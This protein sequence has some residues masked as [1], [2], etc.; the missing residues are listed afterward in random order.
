MKKIFV[1]PLC[2]LC[3]CNISACRSNSDT[4]NTSDVFIEDEVSFTNEEVN[5]GRRCGVNGVSCND[6]A[7]TNY[8]RTEADYRAY[9]ERTKRDH[10]Y[11]QAATGNNLTATVRPGVEEDV[12]IA[13]AGYRR[14][15][16]RQQPAV[17]DRVFIETQ[18][19][20]VA[21]APRESYSAP[22]MRDEQLGI[23]KK[24]AP[25]L[26]TTLLDAPAINPTSPKGAGAEYITVK[27]AANGR[28]TT[29]IQSTVTEEQSITTDGQST[30]TNQHRYEVTCTEECDDFINQ[31][32]DIITSEFTE[33]SFDIAD[34]IDDTED[35]TEVKFTD[36][37]QET[38]VV[39]DIS[40]DEI[41]ISDDTVLTWEAEEGD[42]LRE[43]LTKWS[44]MAGWK[45][46]WQTNRNYILS[47]GVMFKG[48]F[49]DVSSALIRAFARARPAP[50]A[51]YYK[52][53]R[54]I[55]VETMEN[56]NAY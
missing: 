25:A 49:A 31:D 17:E 34:Y 38:K 41:K 55:V 19:Q 47:A 54:V 56:E 44:A 43:L 40:I 37:G 3:V 23:T 53:N 14:T 29:R 22:K 4:I 52:G 26:E 11:T 18:T 9:G 39:T 16:A 13:P 7:L 36:I 32:S 51:T 20:K 5:A 1:L 21:E 27:T 30:V 2:L 33:E 8:T 15:K 6:T 35:D 48:K 42:N 24:I 46:L 12:V 45:L 50:I 28:P 10:L